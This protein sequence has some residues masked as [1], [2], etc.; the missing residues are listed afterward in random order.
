MV[1][2]LKQLKSYFMNNRPK[3]LNMFKKYISIVN[4]VPY[5]LSSL[6]LIVLTQ[7]PKQ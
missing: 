4:K 6:Y 2:Y 7:V 1:G 3:K 5:G